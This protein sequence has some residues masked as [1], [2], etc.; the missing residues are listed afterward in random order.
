MQPEKILV[1]PCKSHDSPS[2]RPYTTIHNYTLK[3]SDFKQY[4]QALHLGPSRHCPS[5][6]GAPPLQW[7]SPCRC[8]SS[9]LSIRFRVLG[10]RAEGSQPQFVDVH[11]VCT[12]FLP[13]LVKKGCGLDKVRKAL[14]W[15]E[16]VCFSTGSASQD[17]L[18]GLHRGCRLVSGSQGSGCRVL[19]V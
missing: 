8:G 12:V 10:F 9:G 7:S 17:F 5:P 1:T 2:R 3:S 6:A 14:G 4:N 11:I 13:L 18:E 16:A 15:I 19:Y